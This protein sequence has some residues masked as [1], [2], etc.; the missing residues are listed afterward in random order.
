MPRR[1]NKKDADLAE[2]LSL[3]ELPRG[4]RIIGTRLIKVRKAVIKKYKAGASIRQ[5]A[6]L[7]DRSYGFIQK[8]LKNAGVKRRPRGGG[9]RK[10]VKP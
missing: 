8:T 4:K 9:Y 2:L 6:E 10:K 7:T 3:R 5:L 1:E